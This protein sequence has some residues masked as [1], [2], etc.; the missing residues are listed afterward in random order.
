MKLI[1]A[2]VDVSPWS[3]ST[4]TIAHI[5]LMKIR[6]ENQME[7]SFKW[8]NFVNMFVFRFPESER[9]QLIDLIAKEFGCGYPDSRKSEAFKTLQDGSCA[10]GRRLDIGERA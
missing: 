6:L 5:K 8:N 3:D 2:I 7:M 4:V 10:T 9:V 1:E